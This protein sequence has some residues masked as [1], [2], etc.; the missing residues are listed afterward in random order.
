MRHLKLMIDYAFGKPVAD[1]LNT[2]RV[3]DAKTT[4]DYGFRQN[5]EDEEIIRGIENGGYL[6]LTHD[7]NTIDEYRF[8]PCSHAGII[9]IR[10]KRWTEE[11]VYERVRAFC[12]SGKKKF[13]LH[14]VT[15]LHS[16]GAMILTHDETVTVRW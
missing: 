4:T 16:E 11:K 12:R 15:Y 1:I 8:P 10:D 3:V 5:A 6:L 13:A 14:S 7:R 2:I 9:I